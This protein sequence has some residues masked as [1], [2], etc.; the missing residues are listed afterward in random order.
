LN[1]QKNKTK[2]TIKIVQQQ[3]KKKNIAQT[4]QNQLQQERLKKQIT[5]SYNK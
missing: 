3:Q 5:P 4:N 1:D 2:K